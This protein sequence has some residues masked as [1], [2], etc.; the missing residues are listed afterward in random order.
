ME[1][2]NEPIADARAEIRRASEDADGEAREQLLSLD[3]GLTE[4]A[5][6]KVENDG[7]PK[8]NRVKQVEEKIVG[9]ANELDDD[10]RAQDRLETARDYLD[11]YRQE[12]GIPTDGE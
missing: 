12:R 4:L 9:L 8:E 6:D 7:P 2:S 3:E 5:G 10:H 1:H 11:Q